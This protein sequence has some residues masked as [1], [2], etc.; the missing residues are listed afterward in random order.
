MRGTPG[1][2]KRA[3]GGLVAVAL[4]LAYAAALVWIAPK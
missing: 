2:L 3:I 1:D 4:A